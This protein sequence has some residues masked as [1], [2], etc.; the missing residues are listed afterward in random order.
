MSGYYVSWKKKK[1]ESH[2]KEEKSGSVAAKKADAGKNEESVT[3]ANEEMVSET[4]PDAV[5]SADNKDLGISEK[6]AEL[7]LIQK[8]ER[9]P[10][11]RTPIAKKPSFYSYLTTKPLKQGTRYNGFAIASMVLGILALVT[12]Y[13]AFVFGVLAIIFGAIALKRIRE[14]P[15]FKGRGMAIAG[16]V[17]GIV[18]LAAMLIV[19]SLA[20]ALVFR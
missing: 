17:C 3:G 15:E 13:G 10:E 12:Y 20:S 11:V 14:N 4:Q 5:A 6:K 19:F 8:P 1:A 16:I 2:V 9:N 7:P 18:A